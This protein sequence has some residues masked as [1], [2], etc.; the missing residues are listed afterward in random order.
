MC[1]LALAARY[2]AMGMGMGTAGGMGMG[3]ARWWERGAHA[4]R[5]WMAWTTPHA[6]N[7]GWRTCFRMA[8]ASHS[9]TNAAERAHGISVKGGARAAEGEAATPMET[10]VDPGKPE[11]MAEGRTAAVKAVRN[12]CER[13]YGRRARERKVPFG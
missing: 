13:R 7:A 1:A 8:S 10:I 5:K 9:A 6:V 11:S 4:S 2:V 3:I 12:H